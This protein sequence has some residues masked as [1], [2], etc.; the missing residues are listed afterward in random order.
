MTTIRRALAY[1]RPDTTWIVLS[2]VLIGA[3]AVLS[4]L[5]PWPL[6]ILIDSVLGSRGADHWIY[7]LFFYR[8]APEGK[9][10]QILVLA[11]AMLALRLAEPVI[12]TIYTLVSIRIGY[13][14]LLRVRCDLFQKLQSLSLAYHKSQPQGDAIY[15][16]SYDSLGFQSL[17]NALVSVL[18]NAVT[19]VA[20]TWIMFTMN[21]KL[22]IIALAVVPVLLVTIRRY[23][24]IFRA[25]YAESSEADSQLTTAIQRSVSSIGL[26]QAFR[27]EADEFAQ[28]HSTASRSV[29]VKMR[30]HWDE[31]MYWLW[32]G[33]IFALGAAG[34]FWYGATLVLNGQLEVG[35]L[36]VFLMYLDKLYDPL[37]KLSGSGSTLTGCLTQV[38]RAF[39]VLDRDPVI[40]DAPDAAP[41]AVQPRVLELDHVTFEYSKG[42]PILQ[43]VTARIDAGQM[44]A[45]VGSSGVGKTTLLN[46]LPRFYDPTGG[47]LRLGGQDLR[48]IRV[49]DLRK[50]VALVLQDSV[51]LPTTVAENIAYGKA[52]ASRNE[53][54]EAAKLAGADSF[55]RA[56]PQGYDAL[57]NESGS[58]LSGGQRQRIA[59][60]RAL[61]TE[62]PIVVLDEPT[63]A[64]DPQHEQLITQ[65]L[66][67]LK[68]KRTIVIVSHRLSTVA[69]CDQIFVMDEGSIVERGTHDQ[70]LA[71]RGTYFRMARHQ[72]K[73]EESPA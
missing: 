71:A 23:G 16:L 8:L 55:I 42:T 54:E 43:N 5:W 10:Q 13:N 44:V 31:V 2:L 12:R 32:L 3:S 68:G 57:V 48:K 4:L 67:S 7:R 24:S 52:Q 26:V 25:R 19:L 17:L 29:G 1:F 27:R 66:R 21:W 36:T 37:N 62:A 39:E 61:L 9:A 65:T 53:I 50:H 64:L 15:R 45:F 69:D 34:I 28:F 35:V 60:A 20:M 72:F 70:L 18:V 6:A 59:I 63:S 51:I 11:I 73:L 40:H 22:T 14:G 56:L 41:L 46:L 47:A 58:N 49:S 33:I 38:N 30:L